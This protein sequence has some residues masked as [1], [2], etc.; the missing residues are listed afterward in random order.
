MSLLAPLVLGVV[1]PALVAA[2]VFLG[3]AWVE[4]RGEAPSA[5]GGALGLGAGYLL[6]HAAV[7]DWLAS[8]R[9]PAWPPP[10]V[11]DW[12]PYLTLVATALGLLEA[13]RPGPAWTRWE[14]RLLVTGLALGLLLG[15]M[16]R[17]FWTTRQAASWLIGLGLGLLVLWGLL[18]GLAARLGPALTLPLLMVAVGTSIVLVLSQSLL[19]GR[20]GMALAAALAVAWAVGRFRPGLSMARGGV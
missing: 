18:E 2:V 8:G 1:L 11:V 16:I 13:I 14:N 3:A 7:Q 9:W 17:N 4:R 19:L 10:D 5:W 12:M 6:G 20:L 15:P